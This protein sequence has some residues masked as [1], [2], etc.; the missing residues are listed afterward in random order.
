LRSCVIMA[1]QKK[2]KLQIGRR[3][4]DVTFIDDIALF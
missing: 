4:H 1:F 2:K 3:V